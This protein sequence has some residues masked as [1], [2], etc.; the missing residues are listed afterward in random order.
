[1]PD[2][3]HD[4]IATEL[5][6]VLAGLSQDQKMLP[7]KLFYDAEGCRLFGEITRLPEYYP[8]RTE[9]A[10]LARIVPMMDK[11]PGCAVIEFG[12]SDERKAM[13][14]LDHLGASDYVPIDIAGSALA[15]LAGRLHASRPALAVHPIVADF[16]NR[17]TLPKAIDGKPAIGFFPG[18]TIGNLDPASA[19]RFLEQ[20]RE[21]LGRGAKFLVG[22]DLRKDPST[23]IPAYDDAQ[24]VTAAF[25]RNILN[26]V[27]TRFEA[28]FDVARFAH[29]AIWNPMDGRVEMHL[30]SLDAQSVG[31][32]GRT[33]RFV[34]GETIHTENSYKHSLAGFATMAEA[35]G[36]RAAKVWTDDQDLFSLHLLI[37][38]G[39][40]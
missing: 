36:W 39:A 22:V 3:A 5:Q 27:N 14:L 37:A 12:G 1:M 18:S 38:E 9:E 21:V 31:I 24:G 7:A 13:I 6:E 8:T 35:A 15:D 2:G 28:D 16:M 23:L 40:A 32:A 17:I 30:V 25:N 20:A 4:V 10:L 29:R 19:H 33:I 34:A 26:H 11:A